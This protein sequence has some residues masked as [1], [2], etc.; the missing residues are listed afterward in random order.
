R[1]AAGA[2][3]SDASLRR[4][5]IGHR[6]LAVG[7]D[8]TRR[9]TGWGAAQ[10]AQ[11]IAR[12]HIRGGQ[13]VEL[14]LPHLSSA[15]AGRPPA[16]DGATARCDV[17]RGANRRARARQVL[18]ISRRRAEGAFQSAQPYAGLTR[19]KRHFIARAIARS[20]SPQVRQVTSALTCPPSLPGA[21]RQ[22]IR[23]NEA[24]FFDGCPGRARA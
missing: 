12:R 20:P 6:K 16:S 11:G 5:R 1:S 4:A 15:H 17:T 23:L 19:R 13:S 14:G 22:S 2:A 24:F 21:T 8:R 10:R 3:Q 18:W 7:A 9:A